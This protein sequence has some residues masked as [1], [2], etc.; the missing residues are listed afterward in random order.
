MLLRGTPKDMRTVLQLSSEDRGLQY[1][2][3]RQSL[4]HYMAS[5]VDWGSQNPKKD[6]G[7]AP[8]DIGA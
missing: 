8:M 2:A 6:K 5:L 4:Q 1:A 3:V 7:P